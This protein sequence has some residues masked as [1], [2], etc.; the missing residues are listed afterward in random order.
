MAIHAWVE[1]FPGA[2]IVCNAEGTI[3]EMN[4]KAIQNYQD[5]GGRDLI[6]KDIY[7]CHPEPA[8]TRLHEMMAA[9]KPNIYTTEKNGAHKL[10]YQC[11]WTEGGIFRGFIELSLAL[12]AEMPH[13]VR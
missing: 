12:P 7:A 6:G 13:F 11:P 2:V 10:I 8:R 4:A 5:Q 3:V 9:Q 1:E